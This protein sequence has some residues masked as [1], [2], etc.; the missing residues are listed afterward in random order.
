[1]AANELEEKVEEEEE[2]ELEV[3]EANAVQGKE[4]SVIDMMESLFD[5]LN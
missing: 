5:W 1:M 3:E 2:A 4:E